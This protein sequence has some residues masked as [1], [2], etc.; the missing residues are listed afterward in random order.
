MQ[1]CICIENI[2]F[3]LT[4]QNHL[5]I[6]KFNYCNDLK[7]SD[8]QVRINW[9]FRS[10][11]SRSSLIRVYTFCHSL[12]IFWTHLW[13]NPKYSPLSLTKVEGTKQIT[14]SYQYFELT[15][16][17]GHSYQSWCKYLKFNSVIH[18]RCLIA[19]ASVMWPMYVCN[20]TCIRNWI[21]RSI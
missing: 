21:K 17:W 10:D 4:S 16:S 20:P 5:Y 12:C 7:F 13:W 1:P 3:P 14:S 15:K 19:M 11:C 8:R 9:R 2:N 6:V 18:R